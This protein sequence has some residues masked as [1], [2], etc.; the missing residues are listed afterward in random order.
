MGLFKLGSTFSRN[1]IVYLIVLGLSGFAWSDESL[2]GCES[3]Q[4]FIKA[5][6][7]NGVLIRNEVSNS[8]PYVRTSFKYEGI[9]IRVPL[10]IIDVDDNG[11]FEIVYL[12]DLG[13]QSHVN[14]KVY[15]LEQ[16]QRESALDLI[17]KKR[18]SVHYKQL[19]DSLESKYKWNALRDLVDFNPLVF[20]LEKIFPGQAGYEKN[21]RVTISQSESKP[22]FIID[23]LFLKE[24]AAVSILDLN[25]LNFSESCNFKY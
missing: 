5:H 4:P 3:Q 10:Y 7:D 6:M 21:I 8:I 23:N 22:I 20:P 25:K 2:D 16:F 14:T 12:V 1:I 13:S 17:E 15:I 9:N 18:K 24:I 19:M 11:I